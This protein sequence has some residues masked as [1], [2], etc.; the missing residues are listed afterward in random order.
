VGQLDDGMMA[1]A[2]ETVERNANS[3]VQLINDLLDVS[4]IANGQLR[5]NI[6]PIELAQIMKQ[7]LMRCVHLP[8]PEAS[9]SI[10][11]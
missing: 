5:L 2:L 6:Q 9:N 7:R 11:D 3:Q 1:T 8:K 10:G 4:R